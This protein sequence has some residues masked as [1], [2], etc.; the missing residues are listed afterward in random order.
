LGSGYRCAGSKKLKNKV[1]NCGIQ[2]WE[3]LRVM[4]FFICKEL[5]YGI[6]KKTQYISNSFLFINLA[7]L[8]RSKYKEKNFML[9][10]ES[11]DARF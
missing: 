6:E 3:V 1:I 5:I 2:G 11:P 4:Q 9:G 8:Q 10:K 7:H